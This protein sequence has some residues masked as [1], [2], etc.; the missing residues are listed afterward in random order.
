MN[1]TALTKTYTK[2]IQNFCLNSK[3]IVLSLATIS[4]SASCA[5]ATPEIETYEEANRHTK[6]RSSV[7]SKSSNN[8]TIKNLQTLTKTISSTGNTLVIESGGAITISN[9]EQQAVNFTQDSS[10]STFLNQG[11]LIGGNNTASVQLGAD[12]N[13]GVTIETFDNQG[14]IG[15]GSSKFGVTVWG[16]DNSKSTINNFSN[17]GTIHSNAGESIYF[18]NANISS[19][20]NSG[21]IKSKQDTGVNISQG[22]NIEN[23]NNTGTIEGKR[24]GVNVRST[25]NTFVNDGLITT[26]V[27]GMHW[28]DGIQINA[29]VKTLI[30]K[31]TI[32]GFSAPIKSSGGT[33][34]T[35]TN[36]GTMKGESIGIYMSGGL[37]KTL[38]NSGTINQNNSATWA[39]GIK[40]QSNS[41]IENIINT[42]SIRSNA[43]GIS[44]TGGKFGTLTIKDGGQVYGKYSAI[45]VGRSQTLGDLYIDGSSSKIYGEENGIALDANSRTQ[46]IELKNGGIIKGN[47]HG[48]RLDNGASLSGEMILSGEGSRVEGGSGAGIL[49]RS[50]KIEGSITIK[51][52]ATVTAT[53]NLAIANYRSGSITAGITVSGKNTKLQGNIINLGNA[54][55]GSDI[56]IKDGAKV[57]GGL[58]NQGNGSISG[59]VQVSGGGSIDSITNEGNGA[60]SG[61]ITVDKDSKLDSITNTSTSSTGISGSITNNS[62][63]KLEISNSGNI[64]GKIES[65]G[66]ADMVISNS[67]G[68][69]I[70]GGISSSG[71]GSTSISNSQGSTINNGI[72]VSGSAQVEISNQGSVGKDKNGNT[73]TNNGSGSVGIKDWLVSTDKNT[74]KLDTVVI[75]GSRAV[76]V[77]VENITVD[78]SNVD[79]EELN[80]IN[81]IISGVNQNNIGNIGTNGSGEISLSFDPITGKLTTDFNLNASISGATFR[82]LISTT[83]RRSTFIDNVMGNSMQSFALASSSK[84]QSIAMSEKGNLYADASD[85]IKS[86]LN[87]GSYGSNKEHSLFI[88]PYTSSQNVE[89]SLNEESKGH[90]KGTIIGY[91]TLKDSGIYGVYAGYEDTKMG[92]TYFDINNRTYYAGLKYFNTLFTTEKGQEVYIKAQGKA[93][94]IKND[95]TEKIGNNEAKAEPN[96]YAYGVNTALG[97]NFISNKDIFSPEIGLAYEGGYTEAFSMKDTIGQATVKGGERTYANY[98]NLFSTKTSL[99]WFR[100]WLPNLKTSVEL[101]AK[102]NINPKV[103]AEARFGNIKVSDEFDLPRVQKFVSTSF[104]VP[105]N[106]AFYFSL[107]YNG[108]F[109]KDGNTHTGFAQFNYLW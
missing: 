23:F 73:V 53:S 88:L 102:F 69:T 72:T 107:N 70:S 81:N 20:V 109:D 18:G 45:G 94:L 68:G 3:K 99:T 12:R 77:K 35:L 105:V 65:T 52:G 82:S 7:R 86:D 89:L 39:A 8:Q 2:D 6:A 15:N 9:G 44:V 17:S 4:F 92:S 41:T 59:S 66:S 96:S 80:D 38:I 36:E 103:E 25:I 30:N 16:K 95:L 67:N 106:E 13:N 47:I 100:D 63:N 33:I 60:I 104:I 28:S 58:V 21:T 85:Y 26:T 43:F 108:M 5:H 87:N 97:M 64:G 24:M 98:L 74:G 1:K 90:T 31:G 75:G 48:I 56:K 22:T 11:T 10:T 76:N 14:I 42:G 79:L 54:S 78:Q 71:S 51:D 101:G 37:V 62:D 55:I 29:N 61:S 46:K 91:S 49:N 27:K 84:S 50:G 57:E 32:Q 40:L 93:A 19:F 34:E 83:S